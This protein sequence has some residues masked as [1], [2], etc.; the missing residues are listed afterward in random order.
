MGVFVGPVVSSGLMQAT[1]PWVPFLASFG[2]M[3]LAAIVM[4]FVPETLPPR[5][6]DPDEVASAD[7]TTGSMFRR[8][9][10]HSG[11]Q[12]EACFAMLRQPALVIVLATFLSPVPISIAMNQLFVQYVSKRFDWSLASAGYLL[13]V[14]GT[15]NVLL[16]LIVLPSLSKLL[17]SPILVKGLSVAGKDRLI[18]QISAVFLTLGCLLIAGNG[19]P[20]VIAGLVINTLGAGLSPMCRSLAANFVDAHNTSKLQTLIGITEAISSLAAGPALAGLFSEGMKLEDGWMG[21]PYVCLAAFLALTTLPLF[22]L[23]IPVK[24]PIEEPIM[25]ESGDYMCSRGADGDCLLGIYC[26]AH[27]PL[28]DVTARMPG[29]STYR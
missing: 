19:I 15:V 12:L 27:V 4:I 14:R 18:A 7:D 22:F 25:N 16:L 26:P 2:V 5:K 11:E 24:T 20:L 21:L 3:L 1:S 23:R 28:E 6:A 8:H 10:R 29:R 9:L 13:S 17:L